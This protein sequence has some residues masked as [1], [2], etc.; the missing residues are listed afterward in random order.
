MNR[1]SAGRAPFRAADTGGNL[2]RRAAGYI[3]RQ[4]CYR[5][6][7]I[8]HHKAVV[9][10]ADRQFPLAAVGAMRPC[11]G[12]FHGRALQESQIEQRIDH[13]ARP[14]RKYFAFFEAE[15]LLVKVAEFFRFRRNE[16]DMPELSHASPPGRMFH[17]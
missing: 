5:L 12:D 1:I 8:V 7:E 6:F 3:C 9:M 11:R 17:L 13:H 10:N 4:L 15:V 14:A 16:R 2:R